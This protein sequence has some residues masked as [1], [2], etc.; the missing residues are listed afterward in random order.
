MISTDQN[1]LFLHEP[2]G[3]S[4]RYLSMMGSISHTY[5]NALAYIEKW[6][7][8]LFPKDLFKTIH[9]NSKI[10]HRQL[11]ST[12][13]E[14]TKKLKPMFII[15]PRIDYDGERFLKGT[16][17]TDRRT[18][19]YNQ[20]GEGHLEPF[21]I[22]Y[23]KKIA[24]KY[25]LT[26]SVMYAD[27]ILVFSTLMQQINFMQY[28]QN[29]I[30]IGIPFNLSTM[31]ESY[32]S[33]EMLLMLSE[34]SGIPLYDKSGST[35]EFLDYMQQH[36]IYPI[37]YKLQGSTGTREFYRY[38][39][40]TI[41]TLIDSL[42]CDEG[43]K[44]GHVM[45]SYQVSFT[46]RM[47]FFSSGFYFL[48]SDNINK[49]KYQPPTFEDSDTVVPIFTDPILHEDLNLHPG[50][51]LYQ[52]AS[53]ILDETN[54]DISYESMTNASIR[55]IIDYH[56]KNGLPCFD[57]IDIKIRMQGELL[58]AGKDYDIDFENMVIKFHNSSYGYFTYRIFVY[59]NIE[60]VNNMI[61]KLYSLK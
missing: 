39:P 26:R 20:W 11:K 58:L 22:D 6:L 28:I 41:D 27:V 36:S 48:F 38:Y 12:P 9:V 15:R 10:A 3:T 4:V 18:A 51:T 7:I 31:F 23:D 16:M 61:K 30:T 46:V 17:L 14:F 56:K 47:E 44:T 2:S 29:V 5:G 54:Q 43:E 24:I 45:S 35:K 52:T 42:S 40:V 13:H 21:F 8:D 32:I 37:T 33:Q 34:L 25:Q 59:I 53:C 19:L 57:F 60:Y 55:A 1:D 50:W 49:L